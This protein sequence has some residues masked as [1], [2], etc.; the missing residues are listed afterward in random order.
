VY[1]A[2]P[3][4]Q[5]EVLVVVS[6]EDNSLIREWAVTNDVRGQVLADPGGKV[7]SLYRPDSIPAIYFINTYGEIK[8]KR[9]DFPVGCAKDIDTLLRLY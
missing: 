4:E 6:G 3:R 8:V 5:L 1:G 7:S 9:T 2:W